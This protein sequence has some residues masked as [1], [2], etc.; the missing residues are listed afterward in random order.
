[1]SV[2]EIG[3]WMLF[4]FF[5]ACPSWYTLEF[6]VRNLGFKVILLKLLKMRKWRQGL[7]FHCA[8]SLLQLQLIKV[9]TMKLHLKLKLPN[10][11]ATWSWSCSW[12]C[13]WSW[14]CNN[15]VETSNSNATW[16]CNFCHV[17]KGNFLI[18]CKVFP[19]NF[20]LN[21]NLIW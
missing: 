1:M 13:T 11:V 16:S 19:R 4:L 8:T 2:Y 7:L 10:E 6:L 15:E 3:S 14:S 20:P 18:H 12:S 9:A 5:W 17:S 21:L